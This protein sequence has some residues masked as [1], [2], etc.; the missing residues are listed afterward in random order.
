MSDW[1][2]AVAVSSNSNLIATQ[3]G[4][5]IVVWDAVSELPYRR[6]WLDTTVAGSLLF[7]P[8]NRYLVFCGRNIKVWHLATMQEIAVSPVFGLGTTSNLS[9]IQAA[10]SPDSRSLAIGSGDGGLAVFELGDAVL[11]AMRD[12]LQN[13]GFMI[14]PQP[15]NAL[16]SISFSQ[17]ISDTYS[18]TVYDVLGKMVYSEADAP[19]PSDSIVRIKVNSLPPGTYICAVTISGSTFA[20]PCFVSR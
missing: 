2:D 4:Q 9:P 1:V 13:E 16:F 11:G 14:F 8:N 5:E 7:S 3:S 15:A 20:I 18:I 6:F 19:S 17:E 12:K 10:F